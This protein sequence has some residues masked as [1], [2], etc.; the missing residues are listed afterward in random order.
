[1]KLGWDERD[2]SVK[3]YI[4]AKGTYTLHTIQDGVMHIIILT[5]AN[6]SK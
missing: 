5:S 3:V 1:L 4:S 2:T 6:V